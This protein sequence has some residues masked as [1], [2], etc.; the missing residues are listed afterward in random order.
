[1]TRRSLVP[2]IY[3]RSWP[4]TP[5]PMDPTGG[6]PFGIGLLRFLGLTGRG[7]ELCRATDIY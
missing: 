1:M 7:M 4:I 6:A 5:N 3:L 2:P